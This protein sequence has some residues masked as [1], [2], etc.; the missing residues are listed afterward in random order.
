MGDTR[1][2][3]VSL[4]KGLLENLSIFRIYFHAET[5][6]NKLLVKKGTLHINENL[7]SNVNVPEFSNG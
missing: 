5:N 2:V 7:K 6:L 3:Q 4:S 1:S